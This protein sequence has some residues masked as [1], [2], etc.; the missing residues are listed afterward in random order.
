[1]RKHK[2]HIL[3]SATDLNGY[4]ECRHKTVL[5]LTD[6]NTTLAKK[7]KDAHG[8]LLTKK[9]L[10]HEAAYL[11]SLKSSGHTLIDIATNDTLENRARMTQEAMKAGVPYVSQ[12]ALLKDQWHGFADLLRRVERP[13]SL[14]SYSY[15]AVDI[16]LSRQPEPS[17]I[18]QLCVY[19]D[20]LEQYQGT[21]PQFF[22]VVLGKGDER[23]FQYSDFAQYYLTL[24]RQ[25]EVYV[26]SP[27]HASIPSPCSFCSRCNWQDLC[28]EQWKKDDHLSQ[29]ANIRKSQIDKLENSGIRTLEG[30]ALLSNNTPIPH[31]PEETLA[32]LKSQA[33]LQ[34][35][36]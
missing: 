3:F 25:F 14:G 1:M 4:I 8:E 7:K 22:S 30:L 19:S 33:R 36:K 23:S 26:A 34:L 27:M 10:E 32:K 21:A 11:Q 17:H 20:L 18:I 15:E 12:A 5:S 13:S 9:G 6:L 2:N 28:D 29:V 31:L 35:V 16:K 24:K